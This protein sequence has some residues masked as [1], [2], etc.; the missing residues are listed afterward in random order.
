MGLEEEELVQLMEDQ[1]V[2]NLEPRS[3]VKKLQ[4]NGAAGQMKRL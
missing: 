1:K 3:G 4:G 2:M